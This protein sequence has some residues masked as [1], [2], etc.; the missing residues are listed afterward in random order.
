[1]NESSSHRRAG[2]REKFFPARLEYMAHR[3]ADCR[4]VTPC[5]RL[6]SVR[7]GEQRGSRYPPSA[8][9]SVRLSRTDALPRQHLTCCRS[10]RMARGSSAAAGAKRLGQQTRANG[11]L[12]FFCCAAGHCPRRSWLGL[13]ADCGK[14]T[15]RAGQLTLAAWGWRPAA[16]LRGLSLLARIGLCAGGAGALAALQWARQPAAA[17]LAAMR[18]AAAPHAALWRPGPPLARPVGPGAPLPPFQI[19]A[20]EMATEQ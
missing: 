2:R 11:S 9:G 14:D 13:S 1:M 19:I 15:S 20:C 8:H 18:R 16:P 12:I 7:L 6:V 5:G 4:A 10:R 3:R 17:A